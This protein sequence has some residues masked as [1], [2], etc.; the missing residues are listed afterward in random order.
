[1]TQSKLN[2]ALSDT[3][4]RM[5]I[6]PVLTI[7]NVDD[8]VPLARALLAGGLRAIEITLRTDAALDAIRAVSES[9]PDAFVG[10]GT[11]LEPDDGAKAI[12][13]GARFL[14]SPGLS[15]RLVAAAETWRVPFLPGAVTASEVMSLRDLGYRCLKFFPAEPSG[16]VPALKGLAAPISDVV[17]C[18]TGGI[19]PKNVADYLALNNVAAVG[20]SWVAPADAIKARDWARI[21]QSCRDALAELA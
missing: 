16:G 9:V 10:A 13:A 15:P 5:K 21:E 6:V 17:F 2:P 14:V 4:G 8:A 18:P 19:G 11:I 3:L 20:G 7:D 1:M 12:A